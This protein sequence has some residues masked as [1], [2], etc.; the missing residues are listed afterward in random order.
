MKPV[1]GI[2]VGDF[3]GIGPEVALKAALSIPVRRACRPILIGPIDVFEFYARRYRMPILLKESQSVVPQT[4]SK[5]LTVYSLWQYHSFTLR[6]GIEST[7]AGRVAGEAIS[8]AA[9]LATRG[10]IDG[11]VTA[12]VSKKMMNA[13]GYRYPGQTE[14]L[15]GLTGSADVMMML[16]AGTFRVA[17]ATVHVPLKAVARHLTEELVKRKINCLDKALRTDLAVPKPKIAVLGLNP[18][19]GENGMLGREELDII[20]PAIKRAKH[21]KIAV[22]G[23]FP[24]DGFFGMQMHRQ[25]DAIL[26]IYH[27]QGLIPLKMAGFDQGV[28]FSTGLKIVRTSPDH[29]TAFD[30]AGKN[31]ADPSSMIVAIKLAIA[32]AGQRRKRN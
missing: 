22:D 24:S 26:A 8:V 9:G 25:Y 4:D 19:A 12:P 1:I 3:N 31:N 11:M 32:V 2:T 10:E 18:H 29:G 5:T 20:I 17:L 13:A 14:M 15:A 21:E 16:L 7:E 30:L 28:N 27:D 23:P 6:P